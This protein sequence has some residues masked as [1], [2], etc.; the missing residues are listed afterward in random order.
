M[1]REQI[2][3]DFCHSGEFEIV[4]NPNYGFIVMCD[5]CGYARGATLQHLIAS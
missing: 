4:S 1:N 3:C 2:S 5:E